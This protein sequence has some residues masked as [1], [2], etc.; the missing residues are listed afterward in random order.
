MLESSLNGSPGTYYFYV[1]NCIVT[2][3]PPPT[4]VPPVVIV[5]PNRT[6]CASPT[7]CC[8]TL[9]LDGS[10]SYDNDHG[11]VL[12][13]TWRTN[14]IV[15]ATGP[16]PSVQIC[17]LGQHPIQLAVGDGHGHT[18]TGSVVITLTDC[19]PPVI[20]TCPTNRSV[21]SCSTNIPDLRSQLIAFDN[22]ATSGQITV[23]QIPAPGWT[24]GPGTYPIQ[25]TA[26]DQGGNCTNCVVTFTVRSVE[27]PSTAPV[28]NTGVGPTRA[29]LSSGTL[30]PHFSLIAHPPGSLSTTAVA[31]AP[32]TFWTVV[33]TA[34]SWIG[35]TNNNEVPGAYSFQTGLTNNCGTNDMIIHGRW[36][37]DDCV[38]LWVDGIRRA[39]RCDASG[40]SFGNWQDFTVTGISPGS[41]LA[42]F[43]VTNRGGPMG[44]RVEWTNYCGC[45]TNSTN[46]LPPYI[47]AG[48]FDQHFERGP[49]VANPVSLSVSVGGSPGLVYQWCRDNVPLS[50]GP[51]VAGSHSATLTLTGNLYSDPFALYDTAVYTLKLSNTCGQVVSRGARLYRDLV[52]LEPAPLPTINFTTYTGVVYRVYYRDDLN[53]GTSWN[54]LDSVVGTGSNNIVVDPKPH[55]AMRFYQVQPQADP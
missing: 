26:C 44:L 37:V 38:D 24:V 15:L 50:D 40:Q 25:L 52:R 16:T 5:G 35:N 47:V 36:A 43:V 2:T 17:G 53:P 12:T 23:T 49:S 18:S 45:P 3:N 55:P 19:A 39:S 22:C 32:P 46:C 20:T 4:N 42:Q 14:G 34:S 28:W 11:D 21:V 54:L 9:T 33:G 30:D 29:P 48:P 10:R 6:L 13:Y 31:T 27:T 41:H 7:N 51:K 8:V 1:Q